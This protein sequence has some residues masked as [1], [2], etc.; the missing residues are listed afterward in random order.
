MNS[1]P[2]SSYG[3]NLGEAPGTGGGM[4]GAQD[5][6]YRPQ[7]GDQGGV[8]AVT[9][10]NGGVLLPS[11]YGGGIGGMATSS[12]TPHWSHTR[13]HPQICDQ[14]QLEPSCPI[15]DQTYSEPTWYGTVARNAS[16]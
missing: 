10:T 13:N 9:A 6:Q 12:H 16:H 11:A 7:G 15:Y 4:Y 3:N 14:N 5:R 2:Y 8:V 1:S